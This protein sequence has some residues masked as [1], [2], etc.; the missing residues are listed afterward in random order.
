[1]KVKPESSSEI[2]SLKFAPISWSCQPITTFFGVLDHLV[3]RSAILKKEKG[4]LANPDKKQGISI[5]EDEKE[6]V[7]QFYLFDENSR[8]LPGMKDYVSVR[9]SE[10][11][12]KQKLQKRLLLININELYASVSYI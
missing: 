7:R 3:R 12:K 11:N 4:L 10:G 9:T 1:M 8:Q 5:M 2:F 6:I